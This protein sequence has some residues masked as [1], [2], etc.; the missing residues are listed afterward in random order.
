M[1]WFEAFQA[2]VED[3]GFDFLT[4]FNFNAMLVHIGVAVFVG[5]GLLIIGP[6]WADSTT[7]FIWHP[8]L[9]FLA[10][11]VFFEGV[12]LKRIFAAAGLDREVVIAMHGR[13]QAVA[14][15]VSLLGLAVVIWYEGVSALTTLHGAISVVTVALV[16]SVAVPGVKRLVSGSRSGWNNGVHMQRG[17]IGLGVGLPLSV[18]TGLKHVEALYAAN[19]LGWA[20]FSALLAWAVFLKKW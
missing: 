7:S 20:S 19:L 10:V 1:G 4:L 8:R 15:A 12:F 14:I 6:I 16:G 13:V 2:A 17:M 9:M 5:G 18:L 11:G 3:P